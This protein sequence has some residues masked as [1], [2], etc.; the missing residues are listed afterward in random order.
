MGGQRECEFEKY[1]LKYYPR[2]YGYI[3]QEV[4]N[5]QVAEDLTMDTFFSCWDKFEAFDEEK[6]P[7]QT[8][9]F[10]IV[11]NKLKNHYRNQK[12]IVELDDSVMCDTDEADDVLNAIQLQY[13]RDQLY[14]ALQE[15]NETHRAIVIYKYFENINA[16]EIACRIGLSSGAVRVHLKRALDKIRDIFD[17]N[18]VRW[19]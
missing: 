2:V 13:L 7:F 10:V 15:L 14:I 4:Q 19:E 8:W 12:D 17:K 1:Y 18:N 9:L 3:L 6:A 11:N 16:N 5:K